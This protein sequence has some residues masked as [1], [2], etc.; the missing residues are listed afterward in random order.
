M[1]KIEN[2]SEKLYIFNLHTWQYVDIEFSLENL[3]DYISHF[4]Y[5]FFYENGFG[6][7]MLN[8]INMNLKDKHANYII[9]DLYGEIYKVHKGDLK[10][11]VILD[12]YMRIVDIRD[13]TKKIISKGVSLYRGYCRT[14]IKRNVPNINFRMGP[15]PGTS[16]RRNVKSYRVPK[17]ANEIRQCNIE[18]DKYIRSKRKSKTLI[19]EV[20]ARYTQKSWKTQSRKKYQWM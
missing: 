2:K 13:H 10:K 16:K 3:I 14:S 11:Y 8:N 15:I 19:Q 9:P 12:G 5:S 17:V 18:T 6:N 1:Y 20:H 7:E 4:N